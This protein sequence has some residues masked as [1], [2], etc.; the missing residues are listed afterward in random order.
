M[1]A[2]SLAVQDLAYEVR[3]AE[4]ALDSG[5]DHREVLVGL[6]DAARNVIGGWDNC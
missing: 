1:S 4:Q 6:L 3:A 5:G 2:L